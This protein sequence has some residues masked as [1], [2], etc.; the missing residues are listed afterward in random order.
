M[1]KEVCRKCHRTEIFQSVMHSPKLCYQQEKFQTSYKICGKIFFYSRLPFSAKMEWYFQ[2]N[3]F[4]L[5]RTWAVM[6][7]NRTK[8]ECGPVI[9]SNGD[10]DTALP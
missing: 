6:T 10:D 8:L 1:E 7:Q 3:P 9:G 4:N 2:H 5:L